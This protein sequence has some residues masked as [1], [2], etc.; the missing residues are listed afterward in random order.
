MPNS[1]SHRAHLLAGVAIS[2][3]VAAVAV[4]PATPALATGVSQVQISP[5]PAYF[6]HFQ[7]GS[8]TGSWSGTGL[9]SGH[10]DPR[11]GIRQDFSQASLSRSFTENSPSPCQASQYSTY[12]YVANSQGSGSNTSASTWAGGA[13]C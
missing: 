1:R 9:Y 13:P 8:W 10:F 2:A 4:L 5:S 7:Q 11:P 6:G 12:L 3:L